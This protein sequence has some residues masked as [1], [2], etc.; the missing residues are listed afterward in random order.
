MGGSGAFSKACCTKATIARMALNR[1]ETKGMRLLANAGR[2]RRSRLCG[3]DATGPGHATN[4]GPHGRTS[5][6]LPG[7]TPPA[8][9]G[10]RPRTGIENGIVTAKQQP[11]LQGVT[12]GR[13]RVRA[14]SLGGPRA[15]REPHFQE[16]D[17]MPLIANRRNIASTSCGGSFAPAS[18]HQVSTA[19]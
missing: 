15:S 12:R 10:H 18:S 6:R 2:W 13:G 3:P 7:E 4:R 14:G 8:R 17:L 5:S 9:T 19:M 1:L 16:H 11:E